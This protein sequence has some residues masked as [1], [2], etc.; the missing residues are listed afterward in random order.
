MKAYNKKKKPKGSTKPKWKD[1]GSSISY[2]TL[3]K[4]FVRYKRRD[5][6]GRNRTMWDRYFTIEGR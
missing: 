6:I 5:T 4:Y 2:Y 3:T 1:S